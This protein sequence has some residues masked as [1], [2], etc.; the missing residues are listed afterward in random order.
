MDVIRDRSRPF[1]L[2]L[3]LCL[4]A[5]GLSACAAA[6][7]PRPQPKPRFDGA[8]AFAHLEQQVAFGPRVPGTAGHEAQ[9]AWLVATLRPLSDEVAEDRFEAAGLKLV[10]VVARY[11]P[12]QHQRHLVKP[13]LTGLWQVSRRGTGLMHLHTEVDLEYIKKIGQL[14]DLKILLQTVPAIFRRSGS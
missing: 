12:W 7:E 1:L 9:A 6:G 3:S 10:N 14:T 5:C 11:E 8:R 13:G 4:C 2:V